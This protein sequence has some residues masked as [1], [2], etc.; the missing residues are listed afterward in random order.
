[1]TARANWPAIGEVVE[2]DSSMP[3]G[4]V[5]RGP[6]TAAVHMGDSTV[7]PAH[8]GRIW[9]TVTCERT[10]V[11]HPRLLE[12]IRT[13]STTEPV[14]ELNRKERRPSPDVAHEDHEQGACA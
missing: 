10:G 11:R 1:M 6:V 4:P 8:R 2:T 9:Y 12:A 3:G 5:V 7:I 13:P 14:S